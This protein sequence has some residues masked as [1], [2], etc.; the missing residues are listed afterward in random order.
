MTSKLFYD[1]LCFDF[2][3]WIGGILSQFAYPL[4]PIYMRGILALDGIGRELIRCDK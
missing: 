4:A 1:F 3:T 2:P